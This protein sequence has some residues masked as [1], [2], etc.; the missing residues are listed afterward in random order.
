M[1]GYGQSTTAA[2]RRRR[3]FPHLV[4]RWTSTC[5]TAAGRYLKPWR[6]D[7]RRDFEVE[8]AAAASGYGICGGTPVHRERCDGFISIE[9]FTSRTIPGKIC[10]WRLARRSRWSPGVRWMRTGGKARGRSEVFAGY[11]LRVASV[12]RDY[13]MHEREEAPP[14]SRRVHG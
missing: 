5:A 7:D 4:M 11:R 14:D 10:R 9:R 6:S 12:L 13:G 1:R 2:L 3:L 8:L